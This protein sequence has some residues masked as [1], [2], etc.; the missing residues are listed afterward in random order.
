MTQPTSL[1][2]VLAEAR[3]IGFLGP[4][5]IDRHIEHARGFAS[6][7]GRQ[8]APIR[9]LDLGSGAGLPGLVLATVWPE[10][11]LALLDASERRTV[12]LERAVTELG[13]LDRVR[14]IRGRAEEVGRRD[15]SAVGTTS[16]SPDHS[17]L[18]RWSPNVRPRS[19]GLADA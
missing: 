15:S 8:P 14:V 5:P 16:W 11:E 4:G 17:P 9:A 2:N 1:E 3:E 10:T 18:P 12:F 7:Y 6:A 19:S 13:L